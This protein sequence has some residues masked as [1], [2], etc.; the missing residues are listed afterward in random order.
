MP[1][2]IQWS[3][4]NSANVSS[5][6]GAQA[7]GGATISNVLQGRGS[8]GESSC[9]QSHVLFTSYTCTSGH[10]L[11]VRT[12]YLGTP[13]SGGQEVHSYQV[14][15][16]EPARLV[17]VCIYIYFFLGPHLW[18]MEIP[19]LGVELELQQ[20]AYTTAIVTRDPSRICDQ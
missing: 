8:A 1:I 13:I 19:R 18:H 11:L 20:Q 12:N 2:E 9:Q 15:D 14:W 6:S 3:I 17:T 7:D 4:E 5:D 10:I 16:G